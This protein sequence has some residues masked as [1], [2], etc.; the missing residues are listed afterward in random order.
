MT[1]QRTLPLPP[2]SQPYHESV[3]ARTAVNTDHAGERVCDVVSSTLSMYWH[4]G[5]LRMSHRST[6]VAR[7]SIGVRRRPPG[8]S[9]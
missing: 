3:H 1:K 8:L 7:Q 5:E 2:D 6:S 4:G 9:K